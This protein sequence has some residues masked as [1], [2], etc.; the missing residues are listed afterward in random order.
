MTTISVVSMSR[1]PELYFEFVKSLEKSIPDIIAEYIVFVNDPV[2]LPRY[3]SFANND[4]NKVKIL[5]APE[6]FVFKYGHDTVYNY[7][8]KKVIGD[9]IFKLFDT[10]V[11]E[12]D[13]D[14][15]IEDLKLNAD[16]YGMDTFMERGNVWE[17]KYQLYKRGVLKWMGI[18]HENQHFLIDSPKKL[19]LKGLKV[20]HHNAL[21]P[22]S[23]EELEKNAEGFII[24][25]PTKEGSDSDRR[26]LLYETLTWKIV[27]EGGR[28]DH[29]GWFQK[30]YAINKDM[31][32][33]YYKRAKERF[34][35]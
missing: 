15:F 31:V 29:L 12:I 2:T 4:C 34:K 3:Y 21:D 13:R 9:Y 26:N 32:D 11:C 25:K 23:A 28:H 35:L 6:D 7:I 18:V 24:L 20:Y 17:V 30:H 22:E 27:N 10:D 19:T 8:E 5:N 1:R 16:I 14:V 33:A